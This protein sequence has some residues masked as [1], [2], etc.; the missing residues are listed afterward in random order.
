MIRLYVPPARVRG[1][2]RMSDVTFKNQ[3]ASRATSDYADFLLPHLVKETH[4]LD[5]GCAGVR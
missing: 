1:E 5:C 2:M 3:L 4:L